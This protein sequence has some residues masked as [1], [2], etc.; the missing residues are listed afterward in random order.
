M[1]EVVAADRERWARDLVG[2]SVL[3]IR[4]GDRVLEDREEQCRAILDTVEQLRPRLP[5]F[6]ELGIL[7][8]SPRG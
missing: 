1:T 3:R 7:E 4:V 6:V 2:R 5:K 8:L